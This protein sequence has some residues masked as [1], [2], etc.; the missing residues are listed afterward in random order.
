MLFYFVD[1]NQM[2][3]PF[4]ISVALHQNRFIYRDI[5]LQSDASQREWLRSLIDGSEWYVWYVDGS[6]PIIHP[7]ILLSLF[8]EHPVHFPA[9]FKLKSRCG[10]GVWPMA[11]GLAFLALVPCFFSFVLGCFWKNCTIHIQWKRELPTVKSSITISICG[12]SIPF[13]GSNL[14]WFSFQC[15]AQLHSCGGAT[16]PKLAPC[17]QPIV[18]PASQ[19]SDVVKTMPFLP[20]IWEW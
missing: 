6:R 5:T 10:F 17:S 12:I 1:I 8:W 13:D 15:M 2:H 19:W 7:E 3:I 20:L 16:R 18:H 11:H 14:Q 4:I 9:I